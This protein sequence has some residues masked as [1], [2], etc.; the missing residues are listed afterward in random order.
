MEY[1][2]GRTFEI[3]KFGH[4][5]KYIAGMIAEIPAVKIIGGGDSAVA[6]EHFG[7]TH[8]MTL[9]STG[10][11]A[12]LELLQGTLL[13]GISAL[14]ENKKLFPELCVTE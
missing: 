14:I 8:Y 7:F 3:E 10:G 1:D 13:P 5:T 12:S 4:G 2:E 9:V 11:G 6:V